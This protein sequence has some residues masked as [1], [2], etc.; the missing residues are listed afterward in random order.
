MATLLGVEPYRGGTMLIGGVKEAL[1]AGPQRII[2]TSYPY[3]LHLALSRHL[4]A[5]QV[6]CTYLSVIRLLR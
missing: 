6:G 2:A 1:K 3:Y 4:E 5:S